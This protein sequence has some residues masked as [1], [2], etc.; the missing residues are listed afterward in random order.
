MGAVRAAV[1]VAAPEVAVVAGAAGAARRGGRAPVPDPRKAA[2]GSTAA[3]QRQ[4]IE[5]MKASRPEPSP[6]SSGD[7]ADPADPSPPAPR[8][9]PAPAGPSMPSIP[10]M[11]SGAAQTGSGFVLGLFFWGWV[12]LP[13]LRGGA[14]EV[15]KTLLAK[16]LNK[17]GV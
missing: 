10:G 17:T 3:K 15:R 13:Y 12:A 9:S 11:G 5:D 14:P 6:S 1:K 4:Q 2:P 16:F 7:G 8:S